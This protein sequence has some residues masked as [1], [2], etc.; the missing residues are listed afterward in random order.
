MTVI[1]RVS[2]PED[3]DAVSGLLLKSYSELLR[4]AY[5]AQV[6]EKALPLITT[7]RPDLLSCGSYYVAETGDGRI[8]GAGGWTRHSPT[9]RDETATNGNI[10]HF[11]TDPDFARKGIGRT[12]MGQCI[13]EA[14]KAGLAELNCYSTLNGES[15][16]AACGF[17]AVEDFPIE[18]PGGVVFPSVRMV[19]KL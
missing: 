12:L 8:V 7:A 9:G 11:A 3:S 17:E 14:S 4:T 5:E 6:L 16:Y 2:A 18:L 19:R 10:R 1:V 13:E 15:F